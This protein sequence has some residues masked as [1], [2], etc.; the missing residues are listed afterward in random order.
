MRACARVVLVLMAVSSATFGLAGCNSFDD[1]KDTVSRWVEIG[2]SPSG[3][4]VFAD[5]LPDATPVIPPEK[6]S[7]KEAS[8]ASKKKDKPASKVQRPQTAEKKLP[9][10][11][12]TEMPTPQGAEPQSVPAQPTP[13]RMRTLWP[14]APPAGTFSR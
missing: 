10:S 13:S 2:K 8:K 3:R 14:E 6:A 11:D 5:D 4:G 9:T 7:R 1:L 12:P